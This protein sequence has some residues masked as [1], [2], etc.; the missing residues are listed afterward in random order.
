MAIP[1]RPSSRPF[2]VQVSDVLS[3]S[4][5]LPLTQ[6]HLSSRA[7][8][9]PQTVAEDGCPAVIAAPGVFRPLSRVR[10]LFSP[11]CIRL[12]FERALI[13]GHNST[14]VIEEGTRIVRRNLSL[15]PS[16]CSVQARS[17]SLTFRSTPIFSPTPPNSL[18]LL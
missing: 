6:I 11:S 2:P 14:W 13:C 7:V 12:H 9:T 10:D 17:F 16:I 3:F 18:Q 8:M 5:T 1:R 4:P 15:A